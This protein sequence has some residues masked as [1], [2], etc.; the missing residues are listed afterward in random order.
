MVALKELETGDYMY[1]VRPVDCP[2]VL[3]IIRQLW[4]P[5]GAQE[6]ATRHPVVPAQVPDRLQQ[7]LPPLPVRGQPRHQ[8]ALHEGA[9]QAI[10]V[11]TV[12]NQVVFANCLWRQSGVKKTK[13]T[14]NS[15]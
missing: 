6:E 15:Y 13:F 7:A 5:S 14:L 11:Q 4:F 1:K 9:Q 3:S 8:A 10:Q 2:A 12:T